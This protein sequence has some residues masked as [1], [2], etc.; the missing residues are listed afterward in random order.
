MVGH[1]STKTHWRSQPDSIGIGQTTSRESSLTVGFNDDDMS[2]SCT[3]YRLPRLLPHFRPQSSNSDVDL[4][5]TESKFA[6]SDKVWSRYGY[7]NIIRIPELGPQIRMLLPPLRS[8]PKNLHSDHG[9]SCKQAA[10]TSRVPTLPLN[11]SPE[12]KDSHLQLYQCNISRVDEDAIIM[13]SAR[14]DPTPSP[15]TRNNSPTKSIK[16]IH[17]IL[18]HN[19]YHTFDKMGRSHIQGP[20]S[21]EFNVTCTTP[22]TWLKM[23]LGRSKTMIHWSDIHK[24]NMY[25]YC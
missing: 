3:P 19:R 16:S 1:S 8:Y 6:A 14:L 4:A 17:W 24:A 23:K 7:E 5:L 22:H 15:I 13:R 10:T 12:M 20:Y 18:G 9:V 11:T 21:R 25:I 2:S